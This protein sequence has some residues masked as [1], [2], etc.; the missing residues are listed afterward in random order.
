M[1]WILLIVL[2]GA[3]AAAESPT[4]WIDPDTGHR[5]VR[6][7]REPQTESLYFNLNPYTPDGRKLVVTTPEGVATIDLTTREIKPVLSGRV[8]MIGVGRKSG[9]L[10]FVRRGDAGAVS[11][12]SRISKPAPRGN[13]PGCRPGGRSLRSTPTR[14][15]WLGLPCCRARK[16]AAGFPT[17]RKA[18]RPTRR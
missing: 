7:S 6:L 1:R 11:S 15:C 3:V 14:R 9:Q 5:V 17:H 8:G 12:A 18:R 16:P 2:S 10:Y 4:E 13:S